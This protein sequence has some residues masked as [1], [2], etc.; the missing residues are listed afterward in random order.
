MKTFHDQ[1]MTEKDKEFFNDFSLA[2][3]LFETSIVPAMP[4]KEM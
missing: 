1:T 3:F 4:A 2:K